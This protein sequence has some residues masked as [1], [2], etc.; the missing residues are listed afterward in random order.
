MFVLKNE[1]HRYVG[2][3]QIFKIQKGIQGVSK[4][5]GFIEYKV[6]QSNIMNIK[7]N[8]GCLEIFR[9]YNISQGEPKYSFILLR[10]KINKQLKREIIDE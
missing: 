10:N 2:C 7:N 8:K 1:I 5:L 3:V 6:S 4:S 9:K